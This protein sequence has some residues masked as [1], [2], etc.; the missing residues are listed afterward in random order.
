M[1][2]WPVLNRSLAHP[3]GEGRGEGIRILS[4]SPKVM[5]RGSTVPP[6]VV[7]PLACL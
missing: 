1:E 2:P 4:I 3:M 6:F 7:P 5:E